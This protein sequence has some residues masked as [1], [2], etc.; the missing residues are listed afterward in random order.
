VLVAAL[1]AL[2][3]YAAGWRRLRRRGRPDL[4]GAGRA[5]LFAAGVVVVVLAL[6]SPSTR[7]A[8]STCCRVTCSSTC[9]SATSGPC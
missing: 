6:V 5:A 9:C 1:V 3:L 4:A 8:R 2:A 7:S